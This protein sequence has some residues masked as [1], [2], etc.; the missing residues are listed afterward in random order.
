M[1]PTPAQ[2]VHPTRAAG[3]AWRPAPGLPGGRPGRGPRGALRGDV[4]GPGDADYETARRVW[5]GLI[6][7]RPA[8]LARCAGV[9]DVVAALD[10][11]R[12]HGL[13]LTVRAGAQV[14]GS[15][16][17]DGAL[18]LPD[19]SR[20]RAVHV[21]AAA[22]PPASRGGAT[23][24]EVDRETQ[25]FGLATPG[26]EVSVTGVAGLTLGGGLGMLQR[27]WGLACDNLLAAEVVTADGRVLT[28]SATEHPD[29]FWGLRGGGGL[30]VVTRSS[31]ASTP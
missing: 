23:W 5:N 29:L 31:S 2:S 3:P 16:V 12:A 19:L 14:A 4:L 7:R 13:P 6:D 17:A 28:A 27:K 21:D 25:L 30:G 1:A 10:F 20:M 9:A 22:A 26:G 18:T 8:L 11:A 24:G 15:A